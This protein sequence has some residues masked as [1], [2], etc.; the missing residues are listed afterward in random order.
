MLMMVVVT[1]ARN[2]FLSPGMIVGRFAFV[3]SRSSSPFRIIGGV[4]ATLRLRVVVVIDELLDGPQD[5]AIAPVQRR[6]QRC[7]FCLREKFG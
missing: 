3:L 2:R 4:G 1:V 7:S 6:F 5:V